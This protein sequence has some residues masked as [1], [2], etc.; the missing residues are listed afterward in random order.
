MI[1]GGNEQAVILDHYGDVLDALGE[2]DAAL[3]YWEMS[4]RKDPNPEVKKKYRK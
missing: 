2:K 1:Y 3:G 4:Y